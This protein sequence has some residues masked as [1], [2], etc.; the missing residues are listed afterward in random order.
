MFCRYMTKVSERILAKNAVRE[1]FSKSFID[2]FSSVLDMQFFID[3]MNMYSYCT[4]S[5]MQLLRDL[6]I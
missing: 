5:N 4:G 2:R 1:L 3:L 6:F